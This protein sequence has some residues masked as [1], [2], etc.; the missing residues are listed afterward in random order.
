MFKDPE[1]N[2]LYG[3][4]LEALSNLH[5]C[6]E[7]IEILEKI[8][9]IAQGIFMSGDLHWHTPQVER[10]SRE[11]EL[12]KLLKQYTDLTTPPPNPQDT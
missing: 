4:K 5:D 6:Y 1:A 12:K 10:R 11:Y 7:K 8:K 9:D 3:E 2:R